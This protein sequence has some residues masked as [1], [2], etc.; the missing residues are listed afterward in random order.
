MPVRMKNMR[1]FNNLERLPRAGAGG[2]RFGAYAVNIHSP[3]VLQP[4]A[5]PQIRMQNRCALL[6]DLL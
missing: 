1:G 4:F 6:P 3:N 2:K 5:A